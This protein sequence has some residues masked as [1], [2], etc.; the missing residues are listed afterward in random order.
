[1]AGAD[2]QHPVR[3]HLHAFV[4]GLQRLVVEGVFR[5]LI[6]AGP[7]QRFMRV[8]Q[9]LAAEIRHRV[10]FAPDHVIQHPEAGILH[11]RPNA[12]DVVIA[13]DHPDRAMR[14]QQSARGRQPAAGEIVIG[15]KAGKLVPVIVHR[16]DLGVVGPMQLALKLQVVGGIGKDQV[17]AARRQAVHD[18]YTVTVNNLVQR[19][20]LRLRSGLP[21]RHYCLVLPGL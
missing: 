5:A 6:P 18:L 11:R 1:M 21:R 9:P 13:A 15:G 12:E 3:A 20:G 17:N 4:Q 16:I 14:F 8:G 2:W 10:R 19:Q 7:D